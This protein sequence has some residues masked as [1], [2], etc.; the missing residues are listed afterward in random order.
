MFCVF[1]LLMF[2]EELP[3]EVSKCLVRVGHTVRVF[4]FGDCC[5]FFSV[6]CHQFI[7]EFDRGSSTFLFS[8]GTEDPSESEGLLTVLVHLHRNLVRRTADSLGSDF[9]VGFNVFDGLFEDFDGWAIFDLFSD[10]VEGIVEDVVGGGFLA[11]V[12]QAID[13]LCH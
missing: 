5:T 10:F 7:C 12:H 4:P 11:V 1:G 9:D 3:S 2:R 6:R 8:N 13:E